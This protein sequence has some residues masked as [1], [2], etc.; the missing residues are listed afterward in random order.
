M[1]LVMVSWVTLL[2]VQPSDSTGL[3]TEGLSHLVSPR[4]GERVENGLDGAEGLVVSDR[5]GVKGRMATEELVNVSQEYIDLENGE[6]GCQLPGYAPQ[7][8]SGRRWEKTHSNRIHTHAHT[9]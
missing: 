6:G 7:A 4:H 5:R 2:M 1:K 8:L 3:G 9:S